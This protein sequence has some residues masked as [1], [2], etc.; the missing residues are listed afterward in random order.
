[1]AKK[2]K[3]PKS[4]KIISYILTILGILTYGLYEQIPSKNS[5]KAPSAT[6]IEEK[7]TVIDGDTIKIN[8]NDKITKI[9]MLGLDAPEKAQSP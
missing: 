8:K 4:S 5:P 6:T 1:M 2:N 3:L 9:R 7:F